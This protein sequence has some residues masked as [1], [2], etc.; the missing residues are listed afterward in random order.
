MKNRLNK[1]KAK[2]VLAKAGASGRVRTPKGTSPS[3]AKTHDALE[4][5]LR[6]AYTRRVCQRQVGQKLV[7]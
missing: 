3:D 7:G 2:L 5:L 1:P 4:T 6:E